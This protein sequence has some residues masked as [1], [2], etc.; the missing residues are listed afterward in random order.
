MFCATYLESI[1]T[2][3]LSENRGLVQTLPTRLLVFR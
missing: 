3:Y 2:M 1:E